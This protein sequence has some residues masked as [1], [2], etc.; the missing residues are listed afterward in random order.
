MKD[1]ITAENIIKKLKRFYHIKKSDQ[2]ILVGD[3][4]YDAYNVYELFNRLFAEKE[5]IAEN[6][7][8]TESLQKKSCRKYNHVYYPGFCL[9]C[10]SQCKKG[11]L[12]STS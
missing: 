10:C 8:N 12:E 1:N 2:P 5:V 4:G 3:K 6:K 9:D 7:R 11:N